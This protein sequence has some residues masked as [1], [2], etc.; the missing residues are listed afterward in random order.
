MVFFFLLQVEVVA[1]TTDAKFIIKEGTI[2]ENLL[3]DPVVGKLNSGPGLPTSEVDANNQRIINLADPTD[4]HDAVNKS[5]LDNALSSYSQDSINVTDIYGNPVNPEDGDMISRL[6]NYW[7]LT[8]FM[9]IGLQDIFHR[10]QIWYYAENSYMRLG[11]WEGDGDLN[12]VASEGLIIYGPNTQGYFTTDNTV[13]YARIKSYRIGLFE[14]NSNYNGYIFDFN[15]HNNVWFINDNSGVSLWELNRN[16]KN[17]HLHTLLHVDNELMLGSGD[18]YMYEDNDGNLVLKDANTTSE[19][20]LNELLTSSGHVL[21][22]GDSGEVLVNNGTSWETYK[23]LVV[24]RNDGHSR[25]Q[26]WFKP[27]N[28]VFRLG[29]WKKDYDQFNIPSNGL[30]IYGPN[31]NGEFTNI[32]GAQTTLGPNKLTFYNSMTGFDG[33]ILDFDMA[34]P[35]WAI[36]DNSGGSVLD[37]KRNAKELVVHGKVIADSYEGTPK[38]Y[39]KID[40]WVDDGSGTF[41]LSHTPLGDVDVILNRAVHQ[42]PGEDYVISNNVVTLIGS[43][44]GYKYI[45]S[46]L[47]EN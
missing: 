18:T 6:N 5:Y 45:F 47:Y 33:L 22:D 21:P 38:T 35:N 3:A 31:N 9:K 41:T 1:R 39:K 20:T 15:T 17:L 8:P 28:G 2:T 12:N 4:D 40:V 7:V 44:A 25:K 43:Q 37:I 29:S 26:L 27:D 11:S 13:G 36:R 34:H 24:D 46:Y 23:D 32:K 42:Y 16:T 30:V 10:N 14:Q 19:I